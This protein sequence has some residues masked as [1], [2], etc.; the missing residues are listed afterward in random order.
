M[1]NLRKIG[2]LV[3]LA[4]LFSAALNAQPDSCHLR[5]SLLTCSAGEELYSAW[6]HTAIRVTDKLTGKD[7]VY[8]YGTFDDQDPLFLANFT[9]G[10]MLYSLSSYPYTTFLEEYNFY[11]RG[12]IEQ[13]LDLPCNDKQQLHAALRLNDTDENRY[14]Q[15]Y[16]HTDNCTSRARDMI[17]RNIN[18]KIAFKET[19]P[20]KQ[21]T[22]RNLI[23][24][25][26]N[27][28]SMSWSKFGIDILLGSNLDKKSSYINATFLPDYLM[29]AFD[30]AHTDQGPVVTEKKVVLDIP[31]QA[32][33]NS[34]IT[35]FIVFA[36]LAA[37][38][39]LLSF[40]KQAWARITLNVFDI[41][42]FLILGFLGVLL[43][44]L[45]AIRV[46]DVCRNNFNL[47]WA[48]PTHLPIAFVMLTN[49]T[50]VKKY[51]RVV[52]FLTAATAA[53]WWIIPQQFNAAVVPILAIILVRSWRRAN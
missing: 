50:W 15:Y 39:I 48:L 19:S 52:L 38:I 53:G 33:K 47:L 14:Y 20:A 9:K 18:T 24:I 12:V 7:V 3:M 32:G 43:V 10:L 4:T 6:G 40:F 46:D 49:K 1:I 13:N 5:I 2:L 22:Y 30:S 26:L 34:I 23:H 8:N 25:Y 11:G 51:F 37:V 16:F 36:L 45:W 27:K 31:T 35:P 28:A 44:V 42:F 29:N 17:V 41:T 21:P